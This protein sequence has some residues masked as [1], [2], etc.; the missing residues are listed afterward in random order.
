MLCISTAVALH[1]PGALS[2]CSI[3]SEF[4]P[5]CRSGDLSLKHPGTAVPA[6][7]PSVSSH[8]GRCLPLLPCAPVHYPERC[9]GRAGHGCTGSSIHRAPWPSRV[10]WCGCAV[11]Y[12]RRGNFCHHAGLSRRGAS[13]GGRHQDLA[14]GQTCVDTPCFCIH[15]SCARGVC[16][17]TSQVIAFE[18]Q[19]YHRMIKHSHSMRTCRSLAVHMLGDTLRSAFGR[20]GGGGSVSGDTRF[21]RGRA[22]P[23]S[24]CCG[25]QAA[26][27]HP[28]RLACLPCR[29]P[30]HVG[31][32]L[33]RVERRVCAPR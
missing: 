22:A 32:A 9:I 7:T 12:V 14:T 11:V 27:V 8:A 3:T 31:T 29:A 17:Q 26:L 33:V 5:I 28:A 2:N 21:R 19:N 1:P 23:S 13:C 30:F 10:G 15:L 6:R 20:R 25:A 24:S 16:V 18:A 4:S